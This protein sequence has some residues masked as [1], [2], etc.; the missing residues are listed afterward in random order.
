MQIHL[1]LRA[2]ATAT[3]FLC[4]Y[5]GKAVLDGMTFPDK[6]WKISLKQGFTAH[7]PLLTATDGFELGR[8][9]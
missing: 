4:C 7:M 6:N 5:M 8:R 1:T 2:A 9:Y 3:T